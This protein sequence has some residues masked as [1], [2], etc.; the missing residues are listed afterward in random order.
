MWDSIIG[1]SCHKYHFCCNKSFVM[2]L[3]LSWLK[4]KSTNICHNKHNLVMTK[5]LWWQAY[6]CHDKHVFVMTNHAFCCDK[7][8]L[9][10]T[11]VLSRQNIF[12]TTK[13]A[14]FCCDKRCV[15]SWQTG[16]CCDKYMFVMTKI[17]LVAV[18]AND[19]SHP[20]VTL[21]EPLHMV[22]CRRITHYFFCLTGR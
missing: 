10:A 20:E 4:K 8:M 15:L 16:V 7:S 5:G 14:C 6:F 22:T 9:V 18:P 17:I 19:M 11:K 3:C 12:G 1:G 13:Q 2:T 21:C